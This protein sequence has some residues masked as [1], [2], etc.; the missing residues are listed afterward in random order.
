[1]VGSVPCSSKPFTAERVPL[2]LF[3]RR[4][5]G[6]SLLDSMPM[7]RSCE[8]Y[9]IGPR[10]QIESVATLDTA[11]FVGAKRLVGLCFGISPYNQL[12]LGSAPESHGPGCH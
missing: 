5:P 11:G 4:Q 12:Q 1:M 2:R 7:L 8:R 9:F 3:Y 6:T 10:E